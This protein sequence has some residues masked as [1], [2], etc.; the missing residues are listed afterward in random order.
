MKKVLFAVA[1]FFGAFTASAQ[2]SVLKEAKKNLKNPAEAAQIIEAAL[3][4]PETATN[5]DAWKLAGDIQK[6]IYDAEN[7][8]MY[9]SAID[10][11]KVADTA[12]LYSSLVKLY[13]YY[14]KCDELEQAKVASGEL[15]KAKLRKKNA[16]TLKK[17]RQ[18][19]LSGGGDAYNAGNYASAVKFFGLYADVVN[20]PIFADDVELKNDSLISY[21][22]SYAALA[23]NTIND[24][25]NVIKY[26]TIGKENAEV[27][28]NALNCLALVYAES[29]SVKW[30]ET[31]KEGT[32]KFPER[33]WFVGQLIDYYQKNGKIDEAVVEIDRM[34]AASERPYYYYVK[35]VLLSE[36]N[37]N[38]EVMATC[39]KLISMGSDFTAE[40]YV[41]KGNVYFWEAQ[42]IEQQNAELAIDD[43]KYNENDTKIK[44]LYSK[45]KPFYEEAK[46]LEPDNKQLWG[47][48]LLTIYWKLN[49]AEYEALEKELGY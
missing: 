46:K 35:A 29:D 23:A 13:E 42:E 36:Q 26:G 48:T 9:L 18:N 4:N 45:A 14:L 40:A 7:E 2:E 25:E 34:L 15:K 19:L 6:A 41:V 22:A 37:K 3:T 33:E 47:P 38:D 11:T 27:G 44:D 17:L 20:E 8:K 31:I 16:E 5:P 12:K 39:D 21:Y 28:F 30:L 24:K 1:L 49:K 43:P 32:Q 10:P